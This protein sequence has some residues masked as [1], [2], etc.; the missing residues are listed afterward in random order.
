M[1][2][3]ELQIDVENCFCS[4]KPLR[5]A[6]AVVSFSSDSIFFKK[7]TTRSIAN[8]SYLIVEG[9]VEY[10]ASGEKSSSRFLEMRGGYFCPP[11][12]VTWPPP[13]FPP[14]N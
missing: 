11:K 2:E 12:L 13:P 3:F 7:K 9:R 6:N 4:L 14:Y 1:V 10:N 5:R 8:L